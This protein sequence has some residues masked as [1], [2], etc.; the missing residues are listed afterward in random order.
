MPNR[1]PPRGGS[2]PH[3]QPQA[4][5]L[6]RAPRRTSPPSSQ[7]T[8]DYQWRILR[9]RD[10]TARPL[11]VGHYSSPLPL[12]RHLLVGVDRRRR[13]VHQPVTHSAVE[14]TRPGTCSQA[15]KG[16]PG[17]SRRASRSASS[18]AARSP[19]SNASSRSRQRASSRSFRASR[20]GTLGDRHHELAPRRLHQGLDLPL[21]VAL[22]RPAE[23]VAEQVM[24]LQMRERLGALTGA[25]AQDPRH[26]KRRVVI[27]D[28]AGTHRER[29]RRLTWPRERLPSSPSDT[30]S[31]TTDP[32]CGRIRQKKATFSRCR[33]SRLPPR[34]SRPGHG[35]AGD[36]A[37]RKPRAVDCPRART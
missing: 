22:C 19:C 8:R 13:V 35:P 20:S 26:R 15:S 18:A 5:P 27:E 1:R 31:R 6:H 4:V 25:V 33:R 17:R 24:R 21:V 34:R 16:T 12:D 7:P 10:R 37:E 3:R 23:A 29:R 14:E 32:E 30:P 2:T 11:R 28:R 9:R 36:G